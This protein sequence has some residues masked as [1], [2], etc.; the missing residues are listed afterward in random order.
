MRPAACFFLLGLA[1]ASVALLRA[2]GTVHAQKKQGRK[3][4]PQYPPPPVVN[5][6][7]GARA[8]ADAVALFDGTDVSGWKRRDG[9]PTGCAARD[10]VMVCN[11]GAGDAVSVETFRDAQIHLEFNVPY[12]PDQTGQLRGN[13]GVYLQGCYE[14][15][16]LDSWENPTYADGSC[17]GLYG[18]A[19]PL[20]NASRKPGEWQSFDIVFRAPKCDGSGAVAEPGR[21]T[22]FHNGVL[23]HDQVAIGGAGPGCGN[24]NICEPGPLLLQ[25]HSGF[26]NAPKTE[27][28]FR[29]IW[30][31]RL[32]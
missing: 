8:P 22:A 28:R 11:T 26:P 18:I 21:V 13:S 16:I 3:A 9:S 17:G 14:M 31:R 5:P 20:V 19:P 15:Q 27:M 24:R 4:R 23:I 12:M 10:G 7:D 29:N 1:L 32:P 25:D 2:P 30:L 6:G